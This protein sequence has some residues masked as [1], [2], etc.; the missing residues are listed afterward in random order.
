[1]GV[2]RWV[3]SVMA[4]VVVVGGCGEEATVQSSAPAGGEQSTPTTFAPADVMTTI[5]LPTTASSVVGTVPSTV[6]AP[7]P[8]AA[9]VPWPVVPA[10]EATGDPC[11]DWLD[12]GG[13]SSDEAMAVGAAQL[14][15]EGDVAAVAAYGDARPDVFGGAGYGGGLDAYVIAWFTQPLEEH[16]AALA[17]VVAH[18]DRLVVCPT[19]LSDAEA[20]GIQD[21]ILARVGFDGVVDMYQQPGEPVMVGLAPDQ[22]TL[23][24]EL[25]AD[26]GDAIAVSLG[27]FPY[28]PAD[29][30]PAPVC[31]EASAPVPVAPG[32]TLELRPADT[33]DVRTTLVASNAGAAPLEV[34]DVR[35]VEV[36]DASATAAVFLGDMNTD[37]RMHVVE[38]GGSVELELIVPLASCRFDLGYRLPPGTYTMRAV[39]L[40]GT[41]DAPLVVTE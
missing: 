12:S 16:Q 28:P 37:L 9:P 22:M 5:A 3:L 21:E 11:R 17:A 26:Y 30:A 34:G 29:Q 31:P 19:P 14:P 8:T 40:L 20:R 2:V 33:G 24:D 32:I 18:P 10:P 23:A 1:M 4:L 13:M 6:A 27:A 41:V 15:L 39:T 36:L 25:L 35:V 7:T 38:P